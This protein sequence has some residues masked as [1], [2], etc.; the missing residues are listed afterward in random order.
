M[1]QTS[2]AA[3]SLILIS[4]WMRR[5]GLL[6]RDHAQAF[7]TVVL[8]LAMPALVFL[9]VARA[10]LRSDLLLVPVAGWA[11]HLVM[12]GV[13][14]AVARARRMDRPRTGAF[15]TST[16]VGNTGFFGLPLIAASGAGFS[17]PAAVMFDA[18][19]T[20]IITWTSTIAISTA[21]GSVG[22]GRPR[23]DWRAL[24]HGIMLP[25]MWALLAGLAWN[26]LGIGEIPGIVERPL[27]ILGAAVLPMVM[28][29]AGL[30]FTPRGITRH[31]GDLTLVTV[32]RLAG[33]A[34]VGWIVG[35]ALGLEGATLH[36]VVVMGAMP[37]A[38]M[39]LVLGDQYGLRRDLL[40][41]AVVVTTLLCT[42]TLPIVRWM[43]L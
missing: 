3:L 35:R 36:T 8:Y 22:L 32:L 10:D 37:T 5:R 34:A 19:S 6:H 42:L 18:L 28:V 27:E 21:Y 13:G 7:V 23:I 38:M 1:I 16:A 39:S 17:L 43:V 2:F 4:W 11:M 40:A 14:L 9:I 29:Y 15:L 31:L 33:G 24:R 30:V 12:L 26:V 20:A 41:G 25:P